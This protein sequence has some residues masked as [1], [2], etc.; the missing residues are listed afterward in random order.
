MN[1]KQWDLAVVVRTT[2]GINEGKI[3]QVISRY[4]GPWRDTPNKPGW[5]LD[6]KAIVDTH[7]QYFEYCPDEY[8]RP[9]RDNPGTDETLLWA[10]VPSKLKEKA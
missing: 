6:R 8:L 9:L 10:P 4:D 3:V 7:G 1:C 2:L 5:R